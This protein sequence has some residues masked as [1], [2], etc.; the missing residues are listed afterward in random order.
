VDIAAAELD[1]LFD[2]GTPAARREE[3]A[4]GRDRGVGMGL[5]VTQRLLRLMNGEVGVRSEIGRGTAFW[6]EL[7]RVESQQALQGTPH[8]PSGLDLTNTARRTSTKQVLYD[9]DNPANLKLVR[10]MLRLLQDVNVLTATTIAIGLQIAQDECPDLILLDV[11]LPGM[12][13]LQMLA[14]LRRNQDLAN[15]PVIAVSANVMPVDVERGLAAGFYAYLPKPINI[16][17]LFGLVRAALIMR[18]GK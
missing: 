2:P 6:I 11:D 1:R 15:T 9:E 12:S 14:L 18:G 7:E 13:G 10:S 16:Q 3:G 17:K 4:G 8:G 5:A